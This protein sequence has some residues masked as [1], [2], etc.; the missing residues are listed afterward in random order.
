MSSSRG[1]AG[2]P[3]LS[4]R[5]QTLKRPGPQ[6]LS[7]LWPRF[8]LVF[9]KRK[10]NS[11]YGQTQLISFTAFGIRSRR[12]LE[13]WVAMNLGGPSSGPHSDA[14]MLKMGFI[15]LV[16]FPACYHGSRWTAIENPE[17]NE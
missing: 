2:I 17:S 16:S 4:V 9:K 10:S 11:S 7:R 13:P 8:Q 14:S 5:L 15:V 1:I 12:V 3:E 6:S